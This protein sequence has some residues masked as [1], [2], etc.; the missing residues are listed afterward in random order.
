MRKL[1]ATKSKPQ[2]S[3]TRQAIAEP[4][5]APSHTPPFELTEQSF[6]LGEV[7]AP[8]DELREDLGESFVKTVTSG[9]QVVVG[10]NDREISGLR[11]D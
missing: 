7:G 3:R 8:R 9:E 1:K 11:P 6:Q 4:L 2:R 10:D 5:R